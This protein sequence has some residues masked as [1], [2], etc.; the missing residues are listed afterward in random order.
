MSP[1]ID[2][3]LD[4]PPERDLPPE[5]HDA[6]RR[7]LEDVVADDAARGELPGRM[8]ASPRRP[9]LWRSI[10]VAAT[11]AATAAVLVV[12]GLG[13]GGDDD[14]VHAATPP[15]LNG[16]M[17][18]G[19]PAEPQLRE[20]AV[21]AATAPREAPVS[22]IRTETWRLA[23]S[24]R[25]EGAS[26]S[27]TSAVVPVLHERTFGDDGTVHLREV[28]G[29]PQ[30]PGEEYRRAW[31]SEGH[32]DPE[33]TVLLDRTVPARSLE[34]AY[35]AR[36]AAD[37]ARLRSQLL[38][39][40]PGTPEP[41]AALLRAL[42]EV[43]AERPVPAATR[44]AALTMLADEPGLRYLGETTDRADRPALAFATDGTD[45][46]I[47]RRHVL[48]LSPRDG[49]ILGYEEVATGGDARSLDVEPPAVVAYTVYR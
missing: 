1:S 19:E 41:G 49:R 38:S 43:R 46:G 31:D 3:I 33:G 35:P 13:D 12:T 37:P 45:T 6:I 4:V 21:A 8:P 28:R 39:A 18:T 2:L 30:F 36:L 14:V 11:A 16:A 10:A 48:L 34:S 23:I 9:R 47:S 25:G 26:P 22:A 20:L 24:V 44:Q 27:V 17:G 32:P 29:E 40:S 15:V 7:L 42:H 5:R